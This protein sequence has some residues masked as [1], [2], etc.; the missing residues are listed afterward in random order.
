[1]TETSAD[2]RGFGLFAADHLKAAQ[3]ASLFFWPIRASSAN[4]TS[5]LFTRACSLRTRSNCNC[6]VAETPLAPSRQPPGDSSISSYAAIGRCSTAAIALKLLFQ[7]M[8]GIDLSSL[9]LD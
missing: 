7:D 2:W 6:R 3:V 9:D 8:L 4:H 5:T 1:M